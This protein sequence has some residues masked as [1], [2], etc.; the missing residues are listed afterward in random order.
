MHDHFEPFYYYLPILLAGTLPWCAFLPE[1]IHGIRGKLTL[2]FGETEKKLSLVWISMILIFFSISSSKLVPYIAPVFVPIALLFG[3]LFRRYEE[4][5]AA[6]KAPIPFACRITVIIQ[7]IIFTAVLVLPLFPHDHQIDPEIWWPW[8]VFPLIFQILILFVPDMIRSR[9][10]KGWFLTVYALFALFLGAMTFPVIQ[11]LTPYKSA[12]PLSQ[13]VKTHLPAGSTLY[14]YGIS[15]YGV[16]FYTGMRTP[17]VDDIGE[18]RYGS[19]K[20]SAEERERYFLS[21]ASFLALV[22]TKENVYCATRG[23]ERMAI[24]KKAF[25][26][27]SLLWHNDVYYLMKLK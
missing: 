18:L 8:M 9:W 4:D 6:A 12:W 23:E 22:R 16:D 5:W 21:S 25:P 17:I 2:I 20:L 24:L 14:Q 3:H 10:G 1:A 13:A 11:Y 19:E 7:A 26:A 27:L 15:L